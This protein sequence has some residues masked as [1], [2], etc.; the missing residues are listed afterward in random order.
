VVAHLPTKHKA[1]SSNPNIANEKD[2]TARH[3]W[4][5]PQLFMQSTEDVESSQF[6]LIPVLVLILF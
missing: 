5:L 3:L 4:L 2:N 1:L 6:G